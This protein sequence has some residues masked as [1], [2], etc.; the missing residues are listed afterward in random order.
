[1]F[2][3]ASLIKLKPILRSPGN[4]EITRFR[5]R[6]RVT[7]SGVFKTEK[8][9]NF[10]NGSIRENGYARVQDEFF[11]SATRIALSY[12]IITKIKIDRVGKAKKGGAQVLLRDGIF[13]EY[14]PLHD[15]PADLDG[16]TD[17]LRAQL[18]RNWVQLGNF[19]KKQPLDDIVITQHNQ[20]SS[21]Y[22]KF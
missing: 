14:F 16:V 5:V 21:V 12:N 2:S 7:L 18:K 20:F 19:W 11:T 1:M 9:E 4:G 15:G 10:T 13:V 17:N 8:L 6:V 3:I 22:V